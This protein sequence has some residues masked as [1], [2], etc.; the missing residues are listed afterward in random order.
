MNYRY[1]KHHDID[2][3][4]NPEFFSKVK[5]GKY[6]W[7]KC[8]LC[9]REAQVR[10]KS[11][12]GMEQILKERERIR[13]ENPEGKLKARIRKL[14]FMKN[15]KAHINSYNRIYD[16]NRKQKDPSYK[17]IKNLRTRLWHTLK[18]QK[19]SD[20]T[21]KLTGCSLEELKKH[22][23]KKFED[24]MNWDNYGVWH[25]DHIIP[26]ANFDLSDPEQQKICFHYTNLQPM[27]GEKNIQKG[28][29]LI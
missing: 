3:I 11:K 22:L 15:N 4:E 28:S 5:S 27:W 20:S 1:C 29:R 13:I 7:I 25:V 17:L 26:C 18:R 21:L 9:H 6:I 10:Y 12:P 19:K 16:K 24:G 2:T 8:V 14:K 23:Q